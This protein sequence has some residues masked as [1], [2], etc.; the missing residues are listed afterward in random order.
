M[1]IF[2]RMAMVAVLMVP[3]LAAADVKIGVIDPAMA[4]SSAEEVK[5]RNNTLQRALEQD[6]EKLKRLERE[7]TEMGT[8]L[9]R[10][11]VTMQNQ[12]RSQLE[13]Q[14]EAKGYEIQSL[15]NSLQR[16][17]DNDRK[18]LMEAMGPRFDKAVEEVAKERGLD[19]IINAQAMIFNS[20]SVD[21]TADV[22][23]RLN[24]RR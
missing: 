2:K 10:D 21:I 22:V 24:S 9:Q 18:E 1:T 6:T 7:Y 14:I 11:G 16:R 12:Q 13:E 17:Y 4:I 20:E 8:R 23:R 19:M 5:T 15:R 3:M